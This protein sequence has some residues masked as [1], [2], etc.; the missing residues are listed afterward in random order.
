[1][2][3]IYVR[4]PGQSFGRVYKAKASILH[5]K[6]AILGYIG[7][8]ATGFISESEWMTSQEPIV[9]KFQLTVVESNF[10]GRGKIARHT[11]YFNWAEVIKSDTQIESFRK[12]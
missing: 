10:D 1:M 9:N 5:D 8:V 2:I 11:P 12:L 3:R 6:V 7:F 4:K